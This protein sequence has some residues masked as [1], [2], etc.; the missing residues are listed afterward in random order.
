MKL[1][2]VLDEIK[3]AKG[4]KTNRALA[5]LIGI[6]ERRVPE[7]YR[8]R[9]RMSDDYAKIAMASGHRVDELQA[10]YKLS[11]EKDEKSREV[12]SRYYKSIGGIAASI[13]LTVLLSVTFIVTTTSQALAFTGEK[14]AD[15]SIIQIMRFL[16]RRLRMLNAFVRRTRDIFFPRSGFAY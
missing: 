14:S 12:W 3:A 4:I 6:D 7:Y 5:E 8:G 10:I 1:S 9:E 15:L 11:T 13:F 2:D 16:E